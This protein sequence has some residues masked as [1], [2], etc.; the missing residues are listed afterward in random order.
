MGFLIFWLIVL[1]PVAE[2]YVLIKVGSRI[3]FWDTLTLLIFSAVFG[4]Y[5]AK[6]Q[7][8]KALQKIQIC[9][10]EGR[11]PTH[12]MVDGVL[13]FIGGLLFVFPGFISDGLG[14]LLIFP[15]TR[16]LIRLF[17]LGSMRGNLKT[18]SSNGPRPG[19][20]SSRKDRPIG[21][22]G[23]QDAEIVE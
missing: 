14:L 5:L 22:D 4:S 11:M 8:Q 15:P 9:L 18:Y 19:P 13:I 6:I 10:A 3:G 16:F 12:E 2:V 7:G 21:R 17:F 20:S 1:F 23:A